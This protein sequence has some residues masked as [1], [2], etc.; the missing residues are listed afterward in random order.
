MTPAHRLTRPDPAEVPTR[1]ISRAKL[2]R[3]GRKRARRSRLIGVAVTVAMMIAVRAWFFQAYFIPSPSMQ[4]TLNVGDRVLVN[5]MSYRFGRPQRGQVVVFDGAAS[6]ESITARHAG[7]WDHVL[8]VVGAAPDEDD[9]IKRVIGLPGDRIRCCDERGRLQIN[10]VSLD[11]PYLY[12]GDVASLDPFDVLVPPGRLWVMGDHRSRSAD[13]RSHLGDPGGGTVPINRVV[14][15]AVAVLWPPG[16][17]RALGIPDS[18]ERLTTH[19]RASG[20]RPGRAAA[21]AAVA[22]P[23]RSPRGGTAG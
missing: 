13:S 5:K 18:F 17:L 7:F 8:G 11:E 4:H 1:R 20:D 15:R 10:G 12:P 16:R 9:F 6:F 19:G 21:S 23:D 3:R 2:R 14:G 22:A